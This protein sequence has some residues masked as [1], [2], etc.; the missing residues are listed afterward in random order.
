MGSVHARKYGFPFQQP[1]TSCGT[2]TAL[3]VYQIATYLIILRYLYENAILHIFTVLSI[4]HIKYSYHTTIRKS[5][6]MASYFRFVRSAF[7]RDKNE[8]VCYI[9]CKHLY[10]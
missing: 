4:Y 2:Y 9:Y 1:S 5:S 6:E 7:Y 3:S 8:S 10:T